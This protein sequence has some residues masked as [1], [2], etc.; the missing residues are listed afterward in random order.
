MNLFVVLQL[1]PFKKECDFFIVSSNL[2]N[3]KLNDKH[4]VLAVL[5]VKTVP[6]QSLPYDIRSFP[7]KRCC[8]SSEN[9]MTRLAK[10][11]N[12]NFI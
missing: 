12:Q 4:L 9:C 10:P 1:Q 2:C 3:G 7:W 5:F 6:E 8:K 11:S